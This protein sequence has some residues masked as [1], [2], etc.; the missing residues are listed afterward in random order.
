MLQ[1]RFRKKL[2]CVKVRVS[3][4]RLVGFLPLAVR[5]REVLLYLFQSRI[6]VLGRLDGD[7]PLVRRFQVDIL[8]AVDLDSGLV[9]ENDLR[10]IAALA[11]VLLPA[12]HEGDLC[13]GKFH[14]AVISGQHPVLIVPKVRA[15][16]DM[17]AP[18][19]HQAVAGPRL[20]VNEHGIM[21]VGHAVKIVAG[22]ARIR[23]PP[24]RIPRRVKVHLYHVAFHGQHFSRKYAVPAH[25]SRRLRPVGHA[26]LRIGQRDDVPHLAL[27][28]HQLAFRHDLPAALVNDSVSHPDA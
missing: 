25:D 6:G 19:A 26:A 17:L 28:C 14:H 13:R 24:R 16:I 23:N 2:Q 3:P 11:V 9:I 15:V 21:L 1:V 20:I 18:K 10:L 4:V 12:P 27:P 22:R 8:G 7:V 5:L